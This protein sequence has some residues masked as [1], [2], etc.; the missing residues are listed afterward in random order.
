MRASHARGQ[1]LLLEVV[2]RVLGRYPTDAA[3]D[4]ATRGRLLA[5]VAEQNEAI[6]AYLRQ[7]RRVRD[8]DPATGEELAVAPPDGS[9]PSDG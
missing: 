2:A 9:D 6:R 4:Q 1:G 5:P 7:R 3:E 8:V